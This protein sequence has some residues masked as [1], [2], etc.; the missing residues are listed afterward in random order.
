MKSEIKSLRRLNEGQYSSIGK[1]VSL[2]TTIEYE[3]FRTISVLDCVGRCETV[4]AARGTFD[5]R[6]KL[7]REKLEGDERFRVDTLNDTFL[8]LDTAS[9][10]RGQ[11]AHGLWVIEEGQ[12]VCKFIKRHQSRHIALQTIQ[13]SPDK[14]KLIHRNL[15]CILIELDAIQELLG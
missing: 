7:L 6:K 14:F 13:M 9:E 15:E 5:Q 2:L 3:M 10:L 11:F 8:K 1:T 4:N 12:L